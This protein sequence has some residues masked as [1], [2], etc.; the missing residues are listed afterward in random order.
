MSVVTNAILTGVGSIG[1]SSG[2]SGVFTPLVTNVSLAA[3]NYATRC[4]TP[5]T[6][7]GAGT[8]GGTCKTLHKNIVPFSKIRIVIPLFYMTAN[9]GIDTYVANRTVAAS[10]QYPAHTGTIYPFL[11]GGV[12]K[13][14]LSGDD[15][16]N[17]YAVSDVL[18]LGFTIDSLTYF[19]IYTFVQDAVA[20]TC[21]ASVFTGGTSTGGHEGAA[22]STSSPVDA[23]VSGSV[24]DGFTFGIGPSAL[25]TDGT[26]PCVAIVGDSI[27]NG[28]NDAASGNADG[29]IGWASRYLYRCGFGYVKSTCPG[30][31][32]V[33]VPTNYKCRDY[34]VALS[35]PTA[36]ISTYGT[37]DLVQGL[38]FDTLKTRK[39]AEYAY[40]ENLFPGVPL[41]GTTLFPRTTTTDAHATLANQ[42]GQTG[43]T[44]IGASPR[45]SYNDWIR[46]TLAD[47]KLSGYI[48]VAGNGG[49]SSKNSGK[50]P[51]TGA[52]NYATSDGTHPSS[53]IHT[54]VAA[55]APTYT[56]SI[57]PKP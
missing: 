53:A 8:L 41:I 11:F 6:L 19:N 2:G 52:A 17:G 45:E 13:P 28:S 9:F 55:R 56:I 49:E 50:W 24:A 46:D 22:Y 14:T 20:G 25:L 27:P 57:L 15:V 29:N 38:T 34:L 16:N 43:H 30:E 37:N 40:L 10:L 5:Y 33:N 51:V 31:Q 32:S 26:V 3:R 12:Q 23:T 54:L 1:G 39:L 44:P 7:I 48:D 18:D 42:S 21:Y 4:E 47:A 36:I 35:S